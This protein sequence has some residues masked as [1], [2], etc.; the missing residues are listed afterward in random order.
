MLLL[1]DATQASDLASWPPVAAALAGAF[2][3]GGLTVVVPQRPDVPLPPELT[4][5]RSTIGLRVPDHPS[6]RAV[7]AVVGPLP[8]TSANLS[9][10]PP[11]GTAVEILAQLGD[12][13]D[14]ILDGGPSHGG[15]ASTVVDC[16][17]EVPRI[18][19]VGAIAPAAV[20]DCLRLAALP[21]PAPWEDSGGPVGRA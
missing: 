12:A 16:S 15:P 14:L 10:L 3:P 11:A 5:G 19:R 7:A 2:W 6:P 9:G 20:A 13:I 8:V 1:A 18:L 17:G 21:E 4:G